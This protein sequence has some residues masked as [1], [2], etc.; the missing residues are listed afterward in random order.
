MAHPGVA[1]IHRFYDALARHDAAGM[2]ACYHPD[3]V[4]SDPV[5]PRLVDD[6]P[7]AMWRMRLGRAAALRVRHGEVR[8]EA[9]RGRARWE[10]WYPHGAGRRPVHAVV[11][12]RFRFRDGLLCEHLDHFD[13][14]RWAAQALGP[15]GE[16]LGG[17][18]LFRAGLRRRAAADLAGYVKKS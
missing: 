2:A 4:F 8:V 11:A 14:G 13:L 10:A 9:G 16:L 1:L 5:F 17:A 6:Q 15:V 3:I 7:A 18:A 12:A